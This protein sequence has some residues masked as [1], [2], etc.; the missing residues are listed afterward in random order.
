MWTALTAVLCCMLGIAVAGRCGVSAPEKALNEIVSYC[1]SVSK[2]RTA[3]C[4]AAMHRFCGNV[5]YPTA[6]TTFGVPREFGDGE[7]GMSCVR[8]GWN[9]D[10]PIASLQHYESG[11]TLEKSQGKECI[12]AINQHCHYSYGI[13]GYI[14]GISQEVGQNV[15]GVHCFKPT[16]FENVNWDD[17]KNYIS[18]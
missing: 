7:I 5:T 9:G 3:D 2:S 12:K 6:I 15:L 16:L 1:D 17:I 11:C 10:V 8:T 13:W 18:I 14:A 4:T